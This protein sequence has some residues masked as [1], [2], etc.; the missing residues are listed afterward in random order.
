MTQLPLLF[1]IGGMYRHSLAVRESL[2]TDGACAHIEHMFISYPEVIYTFWS[3][4]DS[5]FSSSVNMRGW[6]QSN[7]DIT[8]RQV[9]LPVC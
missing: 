7:G 6:R 3:F 9:A 2:F 1:I 8:Y 5:A 4:R